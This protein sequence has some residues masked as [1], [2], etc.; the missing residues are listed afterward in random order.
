MWYSRMIIKLKIYLLTLQTKLHKMTVLEK[1][2]FYFMSD[3]SNPIDID[4]QKKYIISLCIRYLIT[5]FGLSCQLIP[6]D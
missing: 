2:F 6:M 5:G 1:Y 4:M 3:Q